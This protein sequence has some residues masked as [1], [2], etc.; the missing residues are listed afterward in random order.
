MAH[1]EM[2]LEMTT[3]IFMVNDFRLECND[4]KSAWIPLPRF[5]HE[6]HQRLGIAILVQHI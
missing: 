6:H 5:I 2:L 1:M 4:K 3:R